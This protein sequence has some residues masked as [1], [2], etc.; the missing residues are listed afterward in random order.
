MRQELNLI[1]ES[2]LFKDERV[3]LSDQKAN[4]N[5]IYP[6]G[7]TPREVLNFCSNN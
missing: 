6:D 5:V 3:I 7:S 4:I 1:R 2:G